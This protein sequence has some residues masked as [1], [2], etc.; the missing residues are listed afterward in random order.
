MR[1]RTPG[2]RARTE[3]TIRGPLELERVGS[4]RARLPAKRAILNKR[5]SAA[6]ALSPRPRLLLFGVKK[7]GVVVAALAAV[8]VG[9]SARADQVPPTPPADLHA[10]TLT[11]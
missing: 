5:E 7:V 11:G 9:G 4:A 2:A 3:A 10:C 1:A 6:F 8:L